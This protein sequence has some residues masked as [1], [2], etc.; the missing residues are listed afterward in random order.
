MTDFDWRTARNPLVQEL[1]W[2]LFSEPIVDQ[3]P[4]ATSLPWPCTEDRGAREIL[5]TLDRNSAQLEQ[6]LAALTDKRL[7]A[8][9][10]AMWTFYLANH[11]QFELLAHN[12][13]VQKDG[14]T[15]GALDL[16]FRDRHLD[17]VIHGEIAVKFYL[18]YP[19]NQ[20]AILE[21]DTA[22]RDTAESHSLER[23]IG[24]NPDDSLTDKISHLA[25]H[26]LPL[27]AREETLRALKIAG[28]PAAQLR[29]TTIKGYLFHPWRQSIPLPAPYNPDHLRGEWLYLADLPALV[30]ANS[31]CRWSL[32]PKQQWLVPNADTH[33]GA[34]DI[35]EKITRLLTEK[36]QPLMLSST[37][38][39]SGGSVFNRYFILPPDWPV[40]AG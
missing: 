34:A 11:P 37:N 7:G 19:A 36:R 9:F 31:Q 21:R 23:W 18:Y 24:P 3:L 30:E 12:W 22:E 39:K 14:R 35:T 32:L 13:P 5:A 40:T 20:T 6:H 33:S 16:L 25:H 8:R 29:A 10:E 28:L 1:G 38:P 27:S 4:P 26:Q 17:A 15:L 2:C